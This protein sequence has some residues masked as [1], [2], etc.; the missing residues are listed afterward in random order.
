MLVLIEPLIERP[1]MKNLI[2][3]L[4]LLLALS[5]PTLLLAQ[6][7]GAPEG[8]K[9]SSAE[10][11]VLRETLK[12][13]PPLNGL[14]Q[15]IDIYFRKMDGVAFRLGDMQERERILREWNQVSTN[16]DARWTYASFLMNTEKI[17]EGF[18]LF[19]NLIKEADSSSKRNALE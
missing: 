17:Q 4:L 3:K 14:Q 5:S 10:I 2:A 19:E 13:P 11:A 12:E 16:L 6:N 1:T 15:N 18:S 8:S 9:L 7:T